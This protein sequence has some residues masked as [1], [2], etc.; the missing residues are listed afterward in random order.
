MKFYILDT[1]YL[2]TIRIMLLPVLQ[3]AQGVILMQYISSII[4]L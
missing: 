3:C 2:K 1:G 4:F